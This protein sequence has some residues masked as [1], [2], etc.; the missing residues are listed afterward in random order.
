MSLRGPGDSDDPMS[1]A[2]DN[3]VRMG[4]TYCIAAGNNF[5]YYKITSP[6]TARK[7]ITVGSIHKFGQ[8]SYFSSKGPTRKTVLIK[9]DIVAPG[10]NIQATIPGGGYGYKMVLPWPPLM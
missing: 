10:E 6:G 1:L 2:V 8:I 4:V 9:P 7:A 5:D 3:A